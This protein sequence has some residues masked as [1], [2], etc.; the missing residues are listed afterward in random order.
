MWDR[1]RQGEVFFLTDMELGIL[2]QAK[3]IRHYQGFPLEKIP[4]TEEEVLQT[5]FH[6][7]GKGFIKGVGEEFQVAEEIGHCLETVK[8]TPGILGLIP[9]EKEFS[10]LCVYPGEEAVAI[11]AIAFKK[12]TFKIRRM[13]WEGL[14]NWIKSCGSRIE[15]RYYLK[16]LQIPVWQ[17]VLRNTGTELYIETEAGIEKF[18]GSRLQR[19][20]K[21][22]KEVLLQ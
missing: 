1:L 18:D 10:Q 17:G 6:L 16:D 8:N 7:T 19:E 12:G 9:K 11:E 20:I 2:L 22:A 15:I 4:N 13:S 21:K 14:E 3:G 5:L